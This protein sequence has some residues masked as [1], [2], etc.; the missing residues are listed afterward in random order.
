LGIDGQT[1]SLLPGKKADFM[2]LD[3]N[4]LENIKATRSINAI[5]K[6]GKQIQ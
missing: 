5:Y 4:P 3:A 1:G 2:V 6:N